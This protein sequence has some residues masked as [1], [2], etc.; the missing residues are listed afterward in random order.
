M[1]LSVS[2]CSVVLQN[3]ID[4][5][6]MCNGMCPCLTKEFA[7]KFREQSILHFNSFLGLNHMHLQKFVD[8][9]VHIVQT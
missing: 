3:N 2:H 6:K 4:C 5:V 1:L 8:F 7:C 9:I